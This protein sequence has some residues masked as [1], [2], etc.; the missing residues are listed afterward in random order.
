MVELSV[1]RISEYV[2]VN[3]FVSKERNT[4]LTKR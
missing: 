3:V 2:S 1:L 4:T